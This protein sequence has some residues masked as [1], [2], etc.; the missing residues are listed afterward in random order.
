MKN[1]NDKITTAIEIFTNKFPDFE[2]W[3]APYSSE[4]N[5]NEIDIFTEDGLYC[6]VN[7]KNKKIKNF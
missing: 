1:T 4:V 3:Y 2:W 5:G 7:V 6:T